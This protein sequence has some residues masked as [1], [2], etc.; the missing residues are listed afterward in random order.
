MRLIIARMGGL[1]GIYNLYPPPANFQGGVFGGFFTT[2][3]RFC[4]ITYI[5]EAIL[6]HPN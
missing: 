5:M 1:L 6:P 3:T 2:Y 4:R